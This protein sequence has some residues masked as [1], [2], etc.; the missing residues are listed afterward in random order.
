MQT[1]PVLT[2]GRL[3]GSN[4]VAGVTFIGVLKD[5]EEA[6]AYW[7]VQ[8]LQGDANPVNGLI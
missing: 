3:E 5:G 6:R 8:Q 7:L 4:D 1:L 2:G